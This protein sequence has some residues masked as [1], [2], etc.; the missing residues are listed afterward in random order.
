MLHKKKEEIVQY[1]WGAPVPSLESF[2]VVLPRT[3]SLT[4]L[5][6][7]YF[8]L[9]EIHKYLIGMWYIPST[10]ILVA[11]TV[12]GFKTRSLR[13]ESPIFS[14]QMIIQVHYSSIHIDLLWYHWYN[15]VITNVVNLPLSTPLSIKPWG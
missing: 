9:V 1:L 4:P 7:S 2:L 11:I 6:P 15:G 10:T 12:H 5:T 3:F 8:L 13:F 14:S